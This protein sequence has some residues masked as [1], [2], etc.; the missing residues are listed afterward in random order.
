MKKRTKEENAAYA[1][2][3]RAKRRSTPV[4][5]L[6]DVAP[7]S[8][9]PPK[10]VAPCVAPREK[11]AP[12]TVAPVAPCPIC[13]DKDTANLILR[14]KVQMLEKELSFYKKERQA[15]QESKKDSPY[16]LGPDWQRRTE[17]LSGQKYP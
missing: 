10:N 4:A 11:V 12:V 17:P 13:K 6:E 14:T 9:A 3:L 7:D 2:M 1:R 16:K 5:P 15:M 8:V